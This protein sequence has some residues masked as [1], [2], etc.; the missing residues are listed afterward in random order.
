MFLGLLSW[1]LGTSLAVCETCRA[2]Q[3][4]SGIGMKR[5]VPKCVQMGI[6]ELKSAPSR[7]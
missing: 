7:L 4:T 6:M 3:E 1:E 5:S 2:G